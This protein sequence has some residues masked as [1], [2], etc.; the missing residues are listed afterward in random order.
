MERESNLLPYITPAAA[1]PV[2]CGRYL[3]LLENRHRKKC[4]MLEKIQQI[5]SG[6]RDVRW[7]HTEMDFRK[8]R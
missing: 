1:A 6:R 4:R 8:E 3:F 7:H 2:W 5:L